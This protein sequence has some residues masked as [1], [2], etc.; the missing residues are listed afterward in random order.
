MQKLEL[1]P[2]YYFSPGFYMDFWTHHIEEQFSEKVKLKHVRLK[3]YREVWIG[4]VFAALQTKITNVKHYVCVSEREP[5]D[6]YVCRF[7]PIT[8]K[9]GSKGT[10]LD[11][12][13]I[14]ITRCDMDS[15]E[16]LLDQI[17]KKNKPAYTGNILLVYIYGAGKVVNFKE[18]VNDIKKIEQVYPSE[19]VVVGRVDK[20]DNGVI[21][22][23]GTFAQTKLYPDDGQHTVNLTDENSFFKSPEV[24]IATRRGVSRELKKLGNLMLVPPN[25]ID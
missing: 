17:L 8:T 25:I 24:I 21:F 3:P 2:G 12:L 22:P 4:A 10:N 18:V 9:Y 6:I 11:R 19:I 14:E 16:M 7:V 15:G 23:Q 13:P 20:T 1:K 5:P